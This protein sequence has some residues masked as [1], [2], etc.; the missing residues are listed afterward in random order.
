MEAS[1]LKFW[2]DCANSPPAG[3]DRQIM[4]VDVFAFGDSRELANRLAVLVRDGVKTAT[5]SALWTY[6]ED[7]K[8]LPQKGDHSIV[9]DGNGV[10][11]A[12]IETVEVFVAPFNEVSERFAYD[13]GEGDRS[14]GYW[15]EAH[16]KYFSR[17]RFKD[18][19]FDEQMPLVCERFRVVRI[20]AF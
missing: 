10:P 16:R 7:Q 6:E 5:C 14:L 12:V 2:H 17:Q 13:E 20:P 11:V 19:A 1:V 9:L 15:R 3:P 4:P 18:R 8:P